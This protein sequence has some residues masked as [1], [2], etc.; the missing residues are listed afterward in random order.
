MVRL[1]G[2]RGIILLYGLGLVRVVWDGLVTYLVGFLSLS[3]SV[4]SV[5]NLWHLA[6][7]YTSNA[8]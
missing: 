4:D 8:K 6:G 2:A 1:Q 7:D 3:S 5:E